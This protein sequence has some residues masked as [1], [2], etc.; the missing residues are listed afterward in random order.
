MNHRE[1]DDLWRLYRREWVIVHTLDRVGESFDD[2]DSVAQAAQEWVAKNLTGRIRDEDV[3]IVL[4]DDG[5]HPYAHVE[6]YKDNL[7]GEFKYVENAQ[8]FAKIEKYEEY[9]I[10][11]RNSKSDHDIRNY[12]VVKL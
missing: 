2:T 9:V 4:H 6:V 11:P 1:S 5:G 12:G 3:K 10:V 8:M 7:K